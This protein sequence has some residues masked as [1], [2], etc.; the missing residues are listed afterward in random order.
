VFG[1]AL[2]QPTGPQIGRA[3]G[4]GILL[5]PAI[6]A[7]MV[8]ASGAPAAGLVVLCLMVPAWALKQRFSMT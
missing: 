2:S 5:M 4:G 6:D 8:A 7:S 3:I 1:P